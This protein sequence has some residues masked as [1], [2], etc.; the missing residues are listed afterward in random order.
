MKTLDK[1]LAV[2][3]IIITGGVVIWNFPADD[4]FCLE[5]RGEVCIDERTKDQICDDL[6]SDFIIKK[7]NLCAEAPNPT[8]PK[9]TPRDH[10]VWQSIKEYGCP[11]PNGTYDISELVIA[12]EHIYCTHTKKENRKVTLA[13]KFRTKTITW[14]EKREAIGILQF[15]QQ[16]L[17]FTGTLTDEHIRAALIN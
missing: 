16:P 15:E 4:P 11:A 17:E 12:P 3:A 6:L 2:G 5:Y 1:L 7:E 13:E 8:I 10:L 9:L 14:L